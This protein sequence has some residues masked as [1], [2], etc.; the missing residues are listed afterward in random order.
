[1]SETATLR[2]ELKAANDNHEKDMK[3]LRKE[4]YDFKSGAGLKRAVGQ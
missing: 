1:V 3:E 2:V 4:L